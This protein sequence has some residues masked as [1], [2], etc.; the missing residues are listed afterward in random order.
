MTRSGAWQAVGPVL[1]PMRLPVARI[2]PTRRSSPSH[3]LRNSTRAMGVSALRCFR[4]EKDVFRSLVGRW[5]NKHP[6]SS[7]L[8]AS[9][10]TS[11]KPRAV[12]PSLLAPPLEGCLLSLLRCGRVVSSASSPLLLYGP[13][14]LLLV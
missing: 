13:L 3:G 14:R 5:R 8:F 11:M 6:W 9:Y 1:L 4:L 7:V 2:D 10:A 12:G